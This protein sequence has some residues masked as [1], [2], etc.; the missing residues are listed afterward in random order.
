MSESTAGLPAERASV[1]HLAADGT[2]GA[3]TTMLDMPHD[4]EYEYDVTTRLAVSPLG[5]V[6]AAGT[7]GPAS[8]VDG[9]D[10]PWL[11]AW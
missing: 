7:L 3:V 9:D 2:P 10:L 11:H 4:G 6:S 1:F 8:G 5:R